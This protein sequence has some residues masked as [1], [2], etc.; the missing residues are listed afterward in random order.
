MTVVVTVL[1]LLLLVWTGLLLTFVAPLVA[2]WREPVLRYPVLILESDDWGAGPQSQA[3]A[4]RSLSDLLQQLRD[5]IGHPAV[6]T[7]GVVL[8]IPDGARIAASDCS[9]YHAVTLLDARFE[10]VR[11]AML[12]GI[13]AGV[14]VPQLHGQ[15]HYWPPAVMAAAQHNPAVREWLISAEPAATED[16]PSHLQSRWVDASEL[17]SRA[18]VPDTIGQAI[19][20]EA[21][22]YQAIFNRAPRVAVATTFVWNDTVEAAWRAT[23]V[24]AV[25]TPGHRATCR[26]AA[27]QPA[28][29]DISMLTGEHSSAGQCYLVRDVYFEP[30][31]GHTSQQLLAGL[32]ARTRQGRACLVEM[33]RFNFLRA[34]QASLKTL[35]TALR[36][37]L[38][39]YPNLRFISPLELAHAITHRDPAWFETRYKPRIVAWCARLDEVPRFRRLAR[40]SGLALPLAWLERFG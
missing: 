38:G 36:D 30:V 40:L 6:M 14:F 26:N 8:E 4:L 10:H 25:I 3:Q 20:T 16:L 17:P 13:E 19:D 22:T 28:C 34:P 21:A 5:S 11:A 33:H 12:E 9:A 32:R 31:L 18:L 2:R 7:L 37:A 27:G 35:E 39:M 29:R 1:A 23:G 24:E 15:C